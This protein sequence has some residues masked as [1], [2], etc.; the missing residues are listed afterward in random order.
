MSQPAPT[1]VTPATAEAHRCARCGVFTD[2]QL[3][4]AW[5]C[6]SCYATC[7]SCCAERDDEA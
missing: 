1:P 5:I 7:G 3:G 6:E 2:L 4:D